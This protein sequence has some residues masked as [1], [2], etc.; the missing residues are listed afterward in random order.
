MPASQRPTAL[1]IL[2]GG[3]QTPNVLS[4]QYLRPDVIAPIASRE[5][6]RP[7]E[8]WDR[9]GPALRQLSRQVLD[10]Q[11]VDAF[12]LRDIRA[13][14]AAVME[15]FPSARWV[16]N[17]TCATTVMS[18]GAYE[19]GQARNADVW[20]FDTA[21]RRVV[22]LAGQPPQGDPYRLSVQEYVQ[23]YNRSAQPAA[24]PPQSWLTLSRQMAQASDEAI[25]FR[26]QLRGSGADRQFTAPRWLTSLD[27]TPTIVQ[28][29]VRAQTAGFIDQIRNNG[30][31][32]DL[33]Q[34][35][36]AFWHFING[37]WLE[38]YAW[39]AARRAGCFDDC[40]YAVQMPVQSGL[41]SVNQIDLAATH[42][43][44]LLIAECKT[45]AR[46]FRTEHLDQLRA[47][48]SMIGGSFVGALFISARSQHLADAQ[49]LAAFKGQAD[50]RQIVVVTGDQLRQLPEILKREAIRPTYA[51]G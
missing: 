21:G 42:A 29:C 16:C 33:H 46:P 6:M 22:A 28:W 18:I 31:H 41:S 37:I 32:Y 38:V 2:I 8:A 3:R 13:T 23:I 25:E 19:E 45:E 36:G 15:R 26:E 24:A 43:A 30:G 20:Y 49:A 48:T 35:D 9:V 7:G 12:D 5:A 11:T 40:H 44:S 10:P 47:I 27:L 1:L 34:T 51:R 50:A 4:A 39:D 17:I 14:C